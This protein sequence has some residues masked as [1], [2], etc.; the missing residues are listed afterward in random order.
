MRRTRNSVTAMG[1]LAAL[2]LLLLAVPA[3]ALP[4]YPPGP[5]APPKEQPV[6]VFHQVAPG[7]PAAPAAVRP[8]RRVA[9]TGTDVVRWTIVAAGFV[10]LGMLFVV[11]SRRA[12]RASA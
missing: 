3:A 10:G 7:A 11:V 1:A 4:G 6:V 12:G 8:Q 5:K 2:T 9:V